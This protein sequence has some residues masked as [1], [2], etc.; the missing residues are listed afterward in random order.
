MLTERY[1]NERLAEL[2]LPAENYKPF[3]TAEERTAW[4]SLAAPL[5]DYWIKNAEA[6]L[7]FEWPSLPAVRYMDYVRNGNRTS[8]QDVYFERRTALSFLVAAECMEG[9]GRFIEQIVNGIWAICEESYWVVPAHKSISL[10][11]QGDALPDVTDQVIDL[12]AGETAA[13]LAWTHYFLKEKLDAESPMI[14]KRIKLEMKRRILDPYLERDDFW[15]MGFTNRRVNNWTPWV[16]SNCLSAFLL[17]ET[18]PNRRTAAVAKALRSLD[19]F[20]R[21]YYNDGGCD[22]GPGYWG[23]AG[24]SL[25]DCLE[26]LY[27]AS[28]GEIN[29]YDEPL[30]R[31]IGRYIYRAYIGGDF[32]VNFADGDTLLKIDADLV[33][34]YGVRI[35]DENMAALGA[36]AYRQDEAA[37]RLSLFRAV[38]AIFNDAKLTAMNA[39]P[40]LLRDVWLDGIQFMVAREKE[41]SNDGLF[42]AAKG[43]HNYESHNHNDV[44]HFI[45]FAGG[46]PFL[47]D[48]GVEEYTSKTFSPRR[49]EIWTMQ[50]AYHQLPTVN[51]VQ[52]AAGREFNATEV[53]YTVSDELVK[54]SMNIAPAYPQEAGIESWHRTFNLHRQEQ[55]Y[56]QIIDSFRLKR[57][58][59]EMTMSLMT[60]C[61]PQINKEGT[62]LLQNASGGSLQIEFDSAQLEATIESIAIE[63]R[64]LQKVWPGTLYRIILR[65]KQSVSEGTW[66]MKISHI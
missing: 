6:Y 12:F 63:D 65:A 14:C 26:L 66:I 29:A 4:E 48:I 51:G 32:F 49:Y 53:A 39:K 55:S 30:V 13:L 18:D 15:W 19:Q 38:P 17:L 59:E 44:G 54:L 50:S 10:K 16:T 27:G 7:D 8:Y 31:E 2:L 25:F 3:P 41:G 11:S 5:K 24:G 58:S 56:F 62:I 23:R 1:V 36:S 33:Y 42:L 61:N 45:V 28:E 37:K 57:P 64:R 35:E 60:P 43:G 34:R 46:E 40:P 47:I 20:F 9:K 52:Q 22:E 21:I